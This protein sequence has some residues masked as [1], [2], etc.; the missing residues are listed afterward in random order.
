VP[1]K[2]GVV[3]KELLALSSRAEGRELLSEIRSAPLDR[4]II[5]DGALST[6]EDVGNV[7]GP[8]SDYK[9]VSRL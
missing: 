3:S 6:W 1:L 8:R 4:S 7:N 2:L 5:S 9:A